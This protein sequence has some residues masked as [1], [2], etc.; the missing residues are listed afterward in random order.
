MFH[1]G[2]PTHDINHRTSV[3]MTSSFGQATN[4]CWISL[5]VSN[6]ALLRKS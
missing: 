1:S 6:W 4:P 5:C 3:V 2:Q